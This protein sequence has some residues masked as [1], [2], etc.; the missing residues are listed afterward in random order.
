MYQS[1]Y[2]SRYLCNTWNLEPETWNPTAGWRHSGNRATGV[3]IRNP[4]LIRVY[5]GAIFFTM[6]AG[7]TFE[8]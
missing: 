5:V 1:I 2:V 8:I 4:E 7:E 6:D 3:I